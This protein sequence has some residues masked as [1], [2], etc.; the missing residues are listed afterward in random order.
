M[1]DNMALV[2]QQEETKLAITTNVM[3]TP[4]GAVISPAVTAPELLC[5][6]RVGSEADRFGKWC[7]GDCMNALEDSFPTDY[8]QFIEDTGRSYHG[9]ANIKSV[10]KRIPIAERCAAPN[11]TF[12]HHAIV[13]SEEDPAKRKALLDKVQEEHWSCVRLRQERG[14]AGAGGREPAVYEWTGYV[15]YKE[16]EAFFQVVPDA[17][18]QSGDLPIEGQK[19]KGKIWVLMS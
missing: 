4:V 15:V 16:G 8:A 12:E 6:A 7:M 5:G 10:C 18:G 11:V 17:D 14:M 9:L 2:S 13:A 1:T 3:F 19:V